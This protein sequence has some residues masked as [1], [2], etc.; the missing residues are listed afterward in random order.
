M[1]AVN[2]FL[3]KVRDL[4][5]YGIQQYDMR[6]EESSCQLG[7]SPGGISI[8]RRNKR[9]IFHDWSK[10][11]EVSFKSKKFLIVISGDGVSWPLCTS[12]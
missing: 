1:E 6:Y 8:F 7:I 3:R 2:E 10:V 4:D 9:I 12:N 11:A 5:T